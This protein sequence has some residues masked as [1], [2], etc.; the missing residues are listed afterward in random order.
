MARQRESVHE[1][2]HP[3]VE[4]ELRLTCMRLAHVWAITCHVVLTCGHNCGHVTLALPW[5]FTKGKETK[6]VMSYNKAEGRLYESTQTRPVP[7]IQTV[8]QESGGD[9]DDDD[10][11]VAPAA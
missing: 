11:D 6:A 7:Y 8:G 4:R 1:L 2:F 5:L 3:R 10:S 9:D